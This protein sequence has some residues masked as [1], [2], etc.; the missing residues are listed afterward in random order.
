MVKS[1]LLREMVCKETTRISFESPW[2]KT[3]VALHNILKC[4]ILQENQARGAGCSCPKIM[5]GGATACPLNLA[6]V[7]CCL[8][9]HEPWGGGPPAPESR[10]GMCCLLPLDP[11]YAHV[12]RVFLSGILGRQGELHWSEWKLD[13]LGFLLRLLVQ[14]GV[15]QVYLSIYLSIHLSNKSKP[16]FNI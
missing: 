12:L 15:H 3:N 9:P 13:C 5:G 6:R 7:G 14:F 10:G 16:L 8:L 2:I 1:H 11:E 4:K